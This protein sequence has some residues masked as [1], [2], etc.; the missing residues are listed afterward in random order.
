SGSENRRSPRFGV[1]EIQP[2]SDAL[3]EAIRLNR[4]ADRTV[5]KPRWLTCR[6]TAVITVAI[7]TRAM[8]AQIE[9]M[10]TIRKVR[11][12]VRPRIC[13]NKL[14][15]GVGEGGG[16]SAIRLPHP[17][18]HPTH[19]LDQVNAELFA[20]PPDKHFNRVRIPIKILVVEMFH[21]FR[22]RNN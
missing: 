3:T 9:E 20:Q 16:A 10:A 8:I 15:A 13:P 7:T 6:K 5:S 22:P 1:P 17:V 12:W 11:V 4:C 2:S 19:C 14:C 21:Q 18:S